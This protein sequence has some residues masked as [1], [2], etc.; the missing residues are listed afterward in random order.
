MDKHRG[1]KGI[2][3]YADRHLRDWFPRLPGY[4]AYV[5][6]LNQVA[7][8]FAPLL[9]LIQQQQAARNSGQVRLIDSFPVALA[10]QGHRFK[11]CVAKELAD[12]GYYSTK[13][14]YYHSVRVP[15]IGSRQPGSLPIPEYIGVTGASD[16]DGKI[17]DQIR[18]QLHNNELYGDKA[19]QR[20]DAEDVRQ[21][22]NLTVLTPVKKQ[23]GQPYSQTTGSMVVY[24][25][26]SRSATD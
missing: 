1:I 18:P 11:A 6:R 21:A 9:A 5:Q 12:S 20:P 3:E 7:D 17:F 16:H 4:V 13:K 15:I 23:K 10:K 25:G 8:V 22:Q 24:S 2:Y 19:Y 26:V 14:L